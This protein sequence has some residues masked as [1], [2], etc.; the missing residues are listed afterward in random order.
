MAALTLTATETSGRSGG[1]ATAGQ[2]R[3]RRV[4]S[5]ER[6]RGCADPPPIGI[7]RGVH[8]RAG[9]PGGPV[10]VLAGAGR[11]GD[12]AGPVA[13]T[14]RRYR[15]GWPGWSSAR[16]RSRWSCGGWSRCAARSARCRSSTAQCSHSAA[17]PARRIRRCPALAGR[18]R[19]ARRRR[20]GRGGAR[21]AERPRRTTMPPR[22]P[23]WQRPAQRARRPAAGAH[24]RSAGRPVDAPV[25]AT[26]ACTPWDLSWSANGVGGGDEHPRGD[27]RRHQPRRPPLLS[28]ASP[29]SRSHRAAGSSGSRRSPARRRGPRYPRPGGSM[30][31][32]TSGIRGRPGRPAKG[33]EPHLG[34]ISTPGRRPGPSSGYLVSAYPR[35]ATWSASWLSCTSLAPSGATGAP[36]DTMPE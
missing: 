16:S 22:P 2:R 4:S 25:V 33:V 36:V 19:F 3:R 23:G 24:P 18:D 9:D 20:R 7:L 21:R 15:A 34:T 32:P 6:V 31:A 11:R 10:P 26:V 29:R 13:R 5:R 17:D 12:G 28:T 8:V 30:P 1:R 27:G 14:G 35:S